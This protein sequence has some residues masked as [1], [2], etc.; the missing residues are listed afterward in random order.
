M[1]K[2][3]YKKKITLAIDLL[4]NITGIENIDREKAVQALKE[5]Y[6]KTR[7][8]PFRGAAFPEDIYDK[9]LATLYIIG[10]Y[11]MGIDADFPD[12]FEKVFGKEEKY[13]KV[14]ETLLSDDPVEEKREKIE[15][16]LGG[17]PDSNEMAR[18]LRMVF[19][20][21]VL[22]F[23]NEEKLVKTLHETIKVFPELENDAKKYA[24]FYI[25]FRL[26]EMIA[27]GEIRNKMDKEARKQA[28]NLK[29]GLGMVMPDDTYVYNIARNVFKVPKRKLLG[30]LQPKRRRKSETSKGPGGE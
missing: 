8:S 27:V 20:K 17:Q 19:T 16:L 26:A 5:A 28:L 25:G 22:G 29:I 9:E 1:R 21:I 23:D 14:I 3:V 12:I 30:I 2:S 15:D 4:G 24:R 7:I 13:E 11:G 18:I 6:E 10:K